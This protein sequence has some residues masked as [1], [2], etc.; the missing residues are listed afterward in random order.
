LVYSANVLDYFTDISIKCK[1][2][3]SEEY[4]IPLVW[5]ISLWSISWHSSI[6]HQVY[7]R[8]PSIL[9]MNSLSRVSRN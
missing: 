9:K 4:T 2:S 1:S 5:K 3:I 7:W 8:S 6:H